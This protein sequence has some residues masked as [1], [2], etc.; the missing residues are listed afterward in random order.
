M[1]K[2]ELLNRIAKLCM[3]YEEEHNNHLLVGCT[4]ELPS[5]KEFEVYEFTGTSMEWVKGAKG[6]HFNFGQY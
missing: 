5:D 6:V 4:V 2:T 1:S 3:E